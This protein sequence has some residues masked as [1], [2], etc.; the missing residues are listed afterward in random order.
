METMR[1]MLTQAGL[2]PCFWGVA[3][4][5]AIKCANLSPTDALGGNTPYHAFW[6]KEGDVSYLRVFGCAAYRHVEIR[7]KLQNP[8]KVG[9]FVGYD[10]SNPRV[11]L[12]YDPDTEWP[13]ARRTSPLTRSASLHHGCSPTSSTTPSQW[14]H[15]RQWGHNRHRR[16]GG[17]LSRDPRA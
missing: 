9:I 11:Y 4:D 3:L 16:Q 12:V 1:C 7:R 6:G 17:L 8:G 15:E 5:V 10:T 14:G 13:T 2:P